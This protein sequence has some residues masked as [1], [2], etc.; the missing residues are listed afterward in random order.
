MTAL[1]LPDIEGFLVGFV[2]DAVSHH[3]S[4]HHLSASH[5]VIHHIFQ[6]WHKCN[7]VNEI[8]I[9]SCVGGDL[10]SFVTFDKVDHS[11]MIQG[12]VKTPLLLFSEEI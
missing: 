2:G 12:M 6:L 9:N 4:K 7:R 11:S 3:T 1:T 8:E 5:E 10:D